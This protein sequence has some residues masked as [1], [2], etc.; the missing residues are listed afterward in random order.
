MRFS[1]AW[2]SWGWITSIAINHANVWGDGLSIITPG[3]LRQ[4]VLSLPEVEEREI[5]GELRFQIHNKVFA[6]LSPGKETMILKVSL[7]DL[8]ILTAVDPE[9]FAVQHNPYSRWIRVSLPTVAPVLMG[10]ITLKAWRL[11]RSDAVSKVV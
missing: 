7:A 6:T 3:E 2:E 1:H 4:F 9:T 10:K 11:V 8:L 5:C